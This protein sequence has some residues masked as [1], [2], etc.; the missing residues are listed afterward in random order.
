MGISDIRHADARSH[1]P[2]AAK[3]PRETSR[4]RPS[5]R[6]MVFSAGAAAHAACRTFFPPSK[7]LRRGMAVLAP[8]EQHRAPAISRT[9]LCRPDLRRTALPPVGVMSRQKHR[10]LSRGLS[11]ALRSCGQTQ[12]AHHASSRGECRAE[13]QRERGSLATEQS[14]TECRKRCSDR[15][16]RQACRCYHPA[17]ASTAIGGLRWTSGPSGS[18][19]EKSQPGSANGHAPNDVGDVRIRREHRQ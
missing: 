17:G 12:D 9:T 11:A 13:Q 4:S 19:P 2:E 10:K 7:S 14:E 3:N 18:A 16:S 15:L 6:S 8:A 1:A 5:F